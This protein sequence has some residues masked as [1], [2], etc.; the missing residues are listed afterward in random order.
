MAAGWRLSEESTS[1]S[2]PASTILVCVH[3][4]MFM[5]VQLEAR[6]EP[7]GYLS[8]L[9]LGAGSITGYQAPGIHMPLPLQPPYPNLLK[10]CV[11]GVKVRSSCLQ[12][13]FF[14]D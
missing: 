9:R 1:L 10:M 2:P 6:E 14:I 3:A 4:C 7:E 11:L 5:C 12:D 8:F 13:R